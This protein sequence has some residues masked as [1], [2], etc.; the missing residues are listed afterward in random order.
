MGKRDVDVTV[1]GKNET[2]GAFKDAGSDVEGFGKRIMG[3]LNPVN[4]LKGGLASLG[5]LGFGALAKKSVEAASE[6]EAAWARVESAVENAGLTFANFRG[7]LDAVFASIQKTTRYSDDAAADAF[8]ALMSITQDYTGS[9]K[10]L[11]LATNIAAAKKIDLVSAAELVG[12]AA[13]GETAAL[14]KQGI[15]IKEGSDAIA[16]LSKRFNGFAERDA[17]SMQGQLLQV[18]NAWDNVLESMGRAILGMGGAGE[19]TNK[20]TDSLNSFAT[21]VDEN[22]DNLAA[23]RDLLL[24][25]AGAIGTIGAFALKPMLKKDGQ[26]FAPGTHLGDLF[27]AQSRNSGAGRSWGDAEVNAERQRRAEIA[28]AERARKDQA[29]RDA[30]AEITKKAMAG[31]KFSAG[32]GGSQKYDREGEDILLRAA[33]FDTM[34]AGKSEEFRIDPKMLEEIAKGVDTVKVSFD[35]LGMSIDNVKTGAIMAFADTWGEAVESIV[36]GSSK[37]GAAIGKAIR[38]GIGG[39]MIAEGKSNLLSAAAM[40]VKGLFNPIDWGRA[41]K[42]FGIGTAQI[43]TGSLFAGG[44]GGGGSG[45]AGGIGAGGFAQQQ[46]EVGGRGGGFTFIIDGKEFNTADPRVEEALAAALRDVLGRNVV[47]I[48]AGG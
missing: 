33:G 30:Q 39:A 24:E 11:T 20:L 27:G 12:K 7:E 43:A 13:I 9:V 4:L 35:D 40:A 41:A 46:N 8:A 17:E 23:V 36:T 16:E 14:K 31:K 3:L 44:G 19:T 34:T 5:V 45:G 38:K 26:L 47:I 10:N 42:L 29:F 28:A 25:I 48:P 32:T 2:K 21:W 1:R 6:S 37:A 15:V 22:K 18:A